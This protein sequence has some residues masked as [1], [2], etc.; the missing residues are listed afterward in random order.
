MPLNSSEF[1][2]FTPLH[3]AVHNNC[4][5]TVE[6]LTK[7]GA[8]INIKARGGST[9]LHLAV[10]GG[11]WEILET[12]L[13]NKADINIKDDSGRTPLHLAYDKSKIPKMESLMNVIIDCLTLS[14]TF[15]Y[16]NP[17]DRKGIS[18]FHIACMRGDTDA[19][20]QI[21]ACLKFCL[22]HG[23]DINHTV[24]LDSDEFGG[25]TPLHFAVSN[26]FVAA[27]EF[28]AKSGANVNVE[29]K[30]GSTPLHSAVGFDLEPT[31]SSKMQV[32]EILVKNKADINVKDDFG[33]TPLHNAFLS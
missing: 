27:T 26:D 12:L 15:R 5:K 8:N 7:S 31:S 9:A 11:K 19:A 14:H 17:V 2:G 10:E 22:Q 24:P 16:S 32:V 4:L 18:H 1:A 6:F 21:C 25:F 33:R 23:T 30:H 20:E 29:A 28:L 13:L 3:F